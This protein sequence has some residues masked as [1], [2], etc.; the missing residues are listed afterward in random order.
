MKIKSSVSVETNLNVL[1]K[2]SNVK[3]LKKMLNLM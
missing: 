3:L 1:E 2:P